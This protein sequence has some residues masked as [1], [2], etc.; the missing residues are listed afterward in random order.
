M[1]R[2]L[3]FVCALFGFMAC[4][5]NPIEEQSAIRTDAPETIRVG[6]EDGE[7]RIQLNEAQKTVWTKNDLVSVFYKSNAN[8]K[9]EYRGETGERVAEL[10]R[11]DAGTASS[12][13]SYVVLVYPYSTDYVLSTASGNI[14]T[15]LPATQHYAT[16]SYAVGENL[17]V[18]RSEFTQFSL[19]SVCG[20]LKLQLTGDGEVVKSIKF[21]GNNGEQVAGLIYVDTATAEATLASEMG[22]TDD[23]NAGGNLIFDDTVVT[24]VTLDCGEGVTLGAEATSFYISLPPQTF[25][26]GFTAEIT[27]ADG[28]K[29]VK[30]SSK[31]LS[32]ERNHIQPMAELPFSANISPSN[33]IWYTATAK[34]EP[35]KDMNTY[36]PSYYRIQS[37]EWDEATG[38]GVIT[39]SED[40]TSIGANV[41]SDQSKLKSIV[42][43]N[44]I[45][46]IGSSAFAD[47]SNLTSITIP[48]SVTGIGSSAF[49][50]C[51][52][53]T[54]ITI[55]DSVTGIG[56]RAFK[57][58]IRLEEFKG[59]FASADGNCL[60]VDGVLHS[61]APVGITEYIIPDGVTEIGE[62]VFNGCSN[63][64]V[65]TI[66]DSITKIGEGAFAYC[67]GF[68]NITIPNSVIEMGDYAFYYCTKLKGVYINNTTP[69]AIGDDVFSYQ[70]ND[71]KIYV[72]KENIKRY[73]TSNAWSDYVNYIFAYDFEAGQYVM[74][75]FEIWYTNGSTTTS[76][77]PCKTDVFGA[78]IISNTY[79]TENECWVIRF[80]GDVTTIGDNAFEKC[81]TLQ[82][83]T[84][85]NSVTSIGEEAFYYCSSLS[86]VTIP[87]SV[88]TIGDWAFR[89][90]SSLTS[91]TM[92]DSVTTLGKAAF[93]DCESLTKF[94]GKFASED[95]RCLIIDGA[96]YAFVPSGL[97][98]YV[99]PE[100]VT[101]IR[102]Y[103]F[104]NSRSLKTLIV[105]DNVT[106]IERYAFGGFSGELVINCNIPD[107]Q[108][109]Y[110]APFS[111]NRFKSIIIGDGVTSIGDYAFYD[112]HVGTT[113][114]IPESVT[115]IGYNA[116][117]CCEGKL[118]VNCNIPDP[119]KYS[120]GAFAHSDFTS[121]TI[122]D[123]VT[124]IGD[125]AFDYCEYLNSI[126]CK[127]TTPPAGGYNM[128]DNYYQGFKIYVPKDSVEAY[129]SAQYW[130]NYADDI[131]SYDFERD[132]IYDP[133]AVDLGLSV[134]WASYNVGATAPEE[135]G[136]YFAW[137]EIS[138]KDDYTLQTY[139]YWTDYNG[140]GYLDENEC[141][142]FD[143]I[144]G[145]P[146][147]D[148]ATA[149]W[150]SL[151]RMPTAEEIKELIDNCTW[152]W[153]TL[154]G[155]NGMRVTAP[156]GNSI[157][158][159]AA[160]YRSEGAPIVGSKGC[161][162]VPT[163]FYDINAAYALCFMSEGLYSHSDGWALGGRYYGQSVRPV[164]E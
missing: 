108:Y 21:S 45:T 39:F 37:N 124:S 152:D 139:Q 143:D 122:G 58:C 100:S 22:G 53:L 97:T 147:Y 156:N 109:S 163:L 102:Y 66:P 95:G 76:T 94:N 61:F 24:E 93:A 121:V 120:T 138:P 14:E 154:N 137:G 69:P 86:S 55:P 129:K 64:S 117:S 140:D 26:N 44:T 131:V 3:L 88:T 51:S 105:P 20:W 68:K 150:G 104:S 158:L 6:F 29:M 159:P 79:D 67:H 85:P 48:D 164:L 126:Y 63:L 54:S 110:D 43:P 119:T 99:I 101:T 141:A 91:V 19:K 41:F 78:N 12:T 113:I 155:V 30:S 8:Q 11:V 84:I 145:N 115:K 123:K 160:G 74:S 111:G 1:K 151:W 130:S 13:M 133:R 59:K 50:D 114:T 132:E 42:L 72:P 142:E 82:S 5:Q 35:Y 40:V 127:A 10:Y 103:A 153:T 23:N 92:G 162:W 70:M 17:M 73:Q 136:D 47:C 77:T 125:Y 96:L 81:K 161:Y 135:Y 87:D 25:E 52:N 33:Q 90:C 128:F 9:W 107:V 15:T 134:R 18:S 148:A 106:V 146:Q 36:W 4:T 98:E 34:V 112:C 71:V 89:D 56:I 65:I 7:T 60:I 149:N 28:S 157:F 62:W 46:Y 116:F 32:I 118:V 144:S 49:E 83:I 75:N 38:K 57:D 80:D 31:A 27:C 16:D 2:L